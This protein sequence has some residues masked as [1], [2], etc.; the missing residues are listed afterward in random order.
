L[1]VE[2][3]PARSNS[4]LTLC[5]HDCSSLMI[6]AQPVPRMRP[7]ANEGTYPCTHVRDDVTE[8]IKKVQ[9]KLFLPFLNYSCV[10]RISTGIVG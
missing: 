3:A 8:R 10:T 1:G 5:E 2:I 7:C 9:V 4:H 6:L